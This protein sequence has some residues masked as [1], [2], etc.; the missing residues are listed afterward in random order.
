[1]PELKGLSL[2]QIDILYRNA[3]PRESWA[4][5]KYILDNDVHD[6]EMSHYANREPDYEKRKVIHNESA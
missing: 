4:Y 6:A 1:M 2:E 5:R 3:S